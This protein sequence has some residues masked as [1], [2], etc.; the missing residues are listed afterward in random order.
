[1]RFCMTLSDVSYY[2]HYSSKIFHTKFCGK[3]LLHTIFFFFLISECNLNTHS[4]ELSLWNNSGQRQSLLKWSP[5][6]SQTT[7]T[8][9]F[10]QGPILFP[11]KRQI[12]GPWASAGPGQ[13]L[14]LACGWGPPSQSL[15][16][17]IKPSQTF[18]RPETRNLLSLNWPNILI[19]SPSLFIKSWLFAVC[20]PRRQKTTCALFSRGK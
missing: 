7:Y 17:P 13:V 5:G 14:A 15:S 18:L 9:D 19:G 2:H 8:Q 16:M 4:R 11:N 20:G 10:L 3:I 6:C 1:M 12:W